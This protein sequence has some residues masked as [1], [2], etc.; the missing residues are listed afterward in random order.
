VQLTQ[1]AT[2]ERNRV[3]KLLEQT[4]V[5]I[6]GVLSDVFGVSGHRMIL[7][8]LEGKSTPEEIAGLARG[9][10]QRKVP[11]LIEALQA[12][13]MSDHERFVIRSCLRHLACLE[14]EIELLDA[15]I[16]VRMKGELFEKAFT[17]LQTI[18]GIGQLAAAAIIAEAGADMTVFPTPEQMASWAG[19]CPG[20]RESAGVSKSG[21][22]THGNVYLR[23]TLVQCAWAAAR[24]KDSLFQERFRR[25]APR[26]GPKRAIVAVAHNML[27]VAHCMLNAGESFRG[28]E[29]T[30]NQRRRLRRA[31]HH[32]R[33][34]RRLGLDVQIRDTL[35]KE[36]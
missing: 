14:E 4:N 3:Q 34:L 19:L 24:K 22:T 32:L 27:T 17:L 21:Q 15:E 30:Q 16:L 36:A 26:L 20:K 23:T 11:Q 8:L 18:P 9:T 7:A 31:H 5:K 10:A 13:R 2:R 25:L 12:N 28:H 1:D 33:C 6:A 29:G 35:G